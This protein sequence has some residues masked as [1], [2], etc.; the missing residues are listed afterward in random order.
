[1]IRPASRIGG[2]V[3]VCFLIA[4]GAV[5]LRSAPSNDWEALRTQ[6]RSTLHISLPLPNVDDKQYGKFSVA[7][8]VEADR[9]TFATGYYLRVPAIV[10]HS[11]GATITKHPALVIVNGHGG[12]KSSPYAWWAGIL[13]ARAGAIV[14][15]YDPLG[16][17]ERNKERRSNTSQH[18]EIQQPESE[19]ARRLSGLMITDVMQAV[20]YLKSRPDVDDKHVAVMG[21]S[22]GSFITAL[23]CAVDSEIPACVLVGGGNLDG[24][25]GHWEARSKPMCEA[26]PYRALSFLGD[27]GAIL[28]AL[29]A[30]RGPSLI[31]NGT[32]DQVEEIPKQGLDF[33]PELRKRTIAA[34]GSAKNVFDLQWTAGG[35]HRPYFLTRPV[36]LWLQ[37]KFKFPN[38]TKKQI[39]GMP[40]TQLGPWAL[41]HGVK[42]QDSVEYEHNEGGTMALGN[43][44]PVVARDQLHALP[45]A[46]W[47]NQQERFV[48]ETWLEHA[49]AA[50]RTGAP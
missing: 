41:S 21:F 16:E 50:V 34:R 47:S 13:Y 36:A 14:L 24:E 19:M 49:P 29:S 18:D 32:E 1:M 15:T 43:D 37:E 45:D 25:G 26:I 22:L 39:E 9:V 7:P 10:Y 5:A 17:F 8:G 33:L 27:R 46:L 42:Q 23:S 35:G 6:I 3:L 30:Q 12:D 44:I 2:C 48:Y 11:A 31:H 38:W 20:R 28:L 40:E 4:A